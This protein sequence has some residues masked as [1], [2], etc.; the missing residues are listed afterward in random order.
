MTQQIGIWP[1]I[2]GPKGSVRTVSQYKLF[3]DQNNQL[4]IMDAGGDLRSVEA[5][6]CIGYHFGDKKPTW[7]ILRRFKRKLR[8]ERKR[9]DKAW[10]ELNSKIPK[11]RVGEAM[12]TMIRGN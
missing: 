2:K 5:R 1:I 9:H 7:G 8:A 12:Q 11:M 10:V 4:W 3:R 6:S